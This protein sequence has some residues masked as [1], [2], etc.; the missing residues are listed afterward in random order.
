MPIGVQHDY[1]CQLWKVQPCLYA[2]KCPLDNRKKRAAGPSW[3]S[4]HRATQVGIADYS[5]VK[6][7]PTIDDCVPWVQSVL[8]GMACHFDEFFDELRS[9]RPD[10]PRAQVRLCWTAHLVADFA[11]KYW[12]VATREQRYIR[13]LPPEHPSWSFVTEVGRRILPTIARY[14][15]GADVR[16]LL[17]R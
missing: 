13:Q 2:G 14:R 4:L 3:K 6:T 1:F 17:R 5:Q 7:P 10:L 16:R 11:Y 9:Q 8:S 15:D 12:Y